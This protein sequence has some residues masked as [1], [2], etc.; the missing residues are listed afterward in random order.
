MFGNLRLRTK[1]V[2]LLGLCA[3][4][5][6]VSVATAAVILRDR[7]VDD[8]VDKLRAVVRSTMAIARELDTEVAA[9]KLT[10]DQAIGQLRAI[11]HPMRFDGGIGYVTMSS[12]EGITLIHG[13]NPS[14]EGKPGGAK[15]SS[16]R[17]ITALEADA[18]RDSDEGVIAYS[19]VKPGQTELVPKVAYVARFAPWQT[20][21]LAGAYT[22]DLEAA[23]N[24]T[25]T[26]LG[27]ITGLVLLLTM[28][29]AWFINRDIARTL[30]RLGD[31]MAGLADGD[32]A[33]AIPGEHRKDELGSMARAVAVFKTSMIEAGRLRADQEAAAQRAAAE[34][35]QAMLALA[36]RFEDSFSAVVSG[37]T[38]QASELQATARLMATTAEETTRESASVATASEEATQN[39]QTVAA[40][41]EELSASVRE[42]GEQV[43]QSSRM[44][45]EAVI[46]ASQSNEQVQGL[47]QAAEKV[48]D[49][50]RIIAGI[51]GQ[52]NLLALNATIEAA[53]AGD[54]GKGFAVVASEVKALANQTA[55]ATEEIEAQIRAI[56]EATQ[57]SVQSILGVTHS[58][59]KVNET[60]S[61]IAAAVEEQSAATQEIARNV[62]QAAHGTSI[63]SSTIAGVNQ[64]ARQ[65][66]EAA[67]HLLASA[68]ELGQNSELLKQHAQEFLLEVRAG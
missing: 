11:M 44:I 35:R 2:L 19:F 50:V 62:Q 65:T 33:I 36:T 30:A 55:K 20:V 18:L 23:L 64:A 32:L 34:R 47:S 52:T 13:V 39:V 4:A 26:R 1:L 5:V 57:V 43:A 6:I 37:V 54:A 8:R 40:A 59:T 17:S 31:A 48:G 29:V 53:R 38:S 27:A 66:G 25:L 9:G 68:G 10:R 22:D 16:G 46:Q 49:V 28:L 15:D 51:A 67:S 24:G 12:S 7:M 3:L 45:N 58:I 61:S 41:A 21:F 42:I 63:V 60:A 14:L 56:R